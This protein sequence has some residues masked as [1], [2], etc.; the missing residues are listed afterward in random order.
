MLPIAVIDL[1]GMQHYKDVFDRI[2]HDDEYYYG[3]FKI[4]PEPDNEHDPNAMR[5]TYEEKTVAYVKKEKTDKVR[6]LLAM[7]KPYTITF[8]IDG[9]YIEG[10]LIF[11]E[12]KAEEPKK[13]RGLFGWRK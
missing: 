1:V 9:D 5:I 13:K 6:E 12:P 4:E 10:T 8:S 7:K 11:N 2:E 3:S